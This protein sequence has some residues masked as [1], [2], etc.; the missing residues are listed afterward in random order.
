MDSV[1]TD[2]RNQIHSLEN[3]ME[4]KIGRQVDTLYQLE[5]R[6]SAMN[7]DDASSKHE[8]ALDKRFFA[9]KHELSD[10]RENAVDAILDYIDARFLR[11]E[12]RLTHNLTDSITKVISANDIL[13]GYLDTNDCL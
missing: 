10:A 7:E 9:M 3:R 2:T 8:D 5:R 12:M 13:K 11:S 4:D 1:V 6:V